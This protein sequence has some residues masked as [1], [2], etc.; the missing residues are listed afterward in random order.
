MNNMLIPGDSDDTSLPEGKTL[1]EIWK[2]LDK[3]YCVRNSEDV[4]SFDRQSDL[5]IS[6][7]ER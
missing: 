6:E 7:E 2:Y 1:H 5:S 4:Q 3:K